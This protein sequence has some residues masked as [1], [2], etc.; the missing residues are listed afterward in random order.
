M[1]F[2]SAAQLADMGAVAGCVAVSAH[3]ESLNSVQ[4]RWQKCKSDFA[5][6]GY[7]EF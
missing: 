2:R 6:K 7:I 5:L 3:A 1:T 4:G